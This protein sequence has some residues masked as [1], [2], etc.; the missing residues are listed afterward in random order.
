VRALD[1]GRV[2]GAALDALAEEP[3]PPG[4]PLLGRD[5]VIVTS[6]IGGHTTEARDA[7]GRTA[8]EDLLAVLGGRA[9]RHAVVAT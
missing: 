5:D 7:M 9:P 6:H 2:T 4:H 8:M 1:S 3:P